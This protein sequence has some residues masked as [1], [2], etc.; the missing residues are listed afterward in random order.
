MLQTP[1]GAAWAEEAAAGPFDWARWFLFTPSS[2]E[3]VEAFQREGIDVGFIASRGHFSQPCASGPG[4]TMYSELTAFEI[5]LA[6]LKRE[7]RT[8]GP[9][10]NGQ[11]FVFTSTKDAAVLSL[12]NQPIFIFVRESWDQRLPSR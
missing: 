2:E 6:E 5:P 1:R 4:R 10:I 7:K 8:R 11:V 3:V 9:E 12:Y